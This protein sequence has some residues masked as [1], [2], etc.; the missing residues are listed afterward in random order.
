MAAGAGAG[1]GLGATEAAYGGHMPRGSYYQGDGY[2]HFDPD[3][4][5]DDDDDGLNDAPQQRNS[6]LNLAAAAGL[7][8]GAAAGAG[9]GAARTF[10]AGDASGNYGPVGQDPE[11][12]ERLTK[13]S[14][15]NKR[16]K[17]IVGGVLAFLVIIGGIVGGVVGGILANSNGSSNGSSGGSESHPGGLYDINS[18]EVKRVL[19]NDQLHKVFPTIDYT[20]YYAQYPQCLSK[21]GGPD[22]N[23]VTLDIARLSQ[24]TPAVRLYGTDCN[25]TELVLEAIDRL[26]MKD[27]MKVWLGVYLDGNQTT[28]DRQMAHLYE[29]LDKYDHSS[30]VGVI[31]GNEVLYAKTWTLPDLA[32]QLADI[33]RNFT[34]KGINLPVST[35]DLGD[36]WDA[37]LAQASDIVMANVHP[38]FA[39]TLA[40]DAA[41]WAYTFW[42]GKDIPLKTA[43][44][45]TAG[46]LTY[47]TQI[48][49]EI[50]WPSQ[51]GNDCGV[52]TDPAYGCTSDTDG[53]V[54]STDNLNTFMDG[55]V[56]D[57]LNNGT[58]FFW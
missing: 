22:Q 18:D 23:N 5:A 15:G 49:S 48:I 34:S 30:F 2:D 25:Q 3:L 41:S 50:G 31:V 43:K 14:G 10:G 17:W 52:A 1:A 13:Q 16:R 54:A 56:C 47:P 20:P 37:D 24:L 32:D 55:W 38:F 8:S 4:I 27:T 9:A 29:I 12:S 19:N 39:G 51:G 6:R 11:K 57:A 7:S 28:N 33:R 21:G 53:A 35:A 46:S 40:K 42:Q 26:D 58:T 36:N 44:T 45:A